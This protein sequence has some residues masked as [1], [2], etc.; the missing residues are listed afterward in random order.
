[1]NANNQL[2]DFTSPGAIPPDPAEVVQRV[3]DETR[4]SIQTLE[5][6]LGNERVENET[7]WKL[8][9]MFYLATGRINDLAKI[10]EQYKSITGIS[11]SAD[12]KKNYT[13]WF[14][15]KTT[16][17]PVIFEIPRKITA[18]SL[19][20]NIAIE[21]G[22]ISAD[23]VLLDF[24]RVQ[25]ID[26]EGLKKLAIFFSA[27]AKAGIKPELKQV[28]RF[29]GCLQHK[30]EK[31]GEGT[32]ALWDVLFA[33]EQFRDNREAFEEK[34]IKFAVLYGISPPSWE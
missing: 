31:G 7:G 6:L 34:A 2:L 14:N 25:E 13:Q 4:S 27:L 1:M 24:S 5:S 28:D 20:D 23:S 26:N 33:Y 22:L 17:D 12:L 15:D 30:A 21:H 3:V 19:P 8:L 10:E 9:A 18:T 32:C 11:L 29:I 16:G